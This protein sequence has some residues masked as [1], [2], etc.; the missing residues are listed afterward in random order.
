MTREEAIKE[1]QESHDMM[2]SY[3]IDE[4]ESRLM[5]ALNMAIKALEQKPCEV[6]AETWGE[7]SGAWTVRFA[8][9]EPCEDAISR[10]KAIMVVCSAF[11]EMNT[12]EDK[13]TILG[14]C[15]ANLQKIKSVTPRRKG[16]WINDK[17][18]MPTCSECGYIPQYDR[19]IDD[20]EYSNFCQ[21]CG[22]RMV[23]PQGK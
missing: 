19:A 23:E 22:A 8:P 21:N 12:A 3:E 14:R 13:H 17:D 18:D 7:I 20:Y 2:R 1:L 15:K 9:N 11:R 4:K 10:E 5:T 6:S 16:R